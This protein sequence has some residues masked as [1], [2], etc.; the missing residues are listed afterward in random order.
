MES[1]DIM[2]YKVIMNNGNEH[3]VDYDNEHYNN[4][5]TD[6]EVQNFVKA[7]CSTKYIEVEEFIKVDKYKWRKRKILLSTRNINEIVVP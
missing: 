5:C 6:G 1:E 2:K 7:L 3:Y 4:D